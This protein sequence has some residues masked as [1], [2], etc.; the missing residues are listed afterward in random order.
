MNFPL[1]LRWKDYQRNTQVQQEQ[2]RT[3]STAKEVN[4]LR[5]CV[6]VH[7]LSALLLIVSVDLTLHLLSPVTTNKH[8]QYDFK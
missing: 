2:N 7:S 1:N 5:L 6:A 4:N 8:T 3:P